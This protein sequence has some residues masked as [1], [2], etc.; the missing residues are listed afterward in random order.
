MAETTALGAAYIAGQAVGFYGDDTV[1]AAQRVSVTTYLPRTSPVEGA[2]RQT[3]W[4]QAEAK[5]E[6]ETQ[7]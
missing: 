6:S 2:E 1:L 3:G 5:V 7:G 4:P